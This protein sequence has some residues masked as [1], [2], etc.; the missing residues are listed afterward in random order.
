MNYFRGAFGLYLFINMIK[1]TFVYP[2]IQDELRLGEL[3]DAESGLG[4]LFW[5]RDSANLPS[6]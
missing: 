2:L 6:T 1:P 3:I 5:S 4:Y